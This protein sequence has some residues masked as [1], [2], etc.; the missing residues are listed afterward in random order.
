[1]SGS[2]F[3]ASSKE[4]Y[5]SESILK[6]ETFLSKN[7]ELIYFFHYRRRIGQS[8]RFCGDNNEENLDH[9]TISQDIVDVLT[10]V[11][12]YITRLLLKSIDCNSVC[13]KCKIALTN[14]P[15]SST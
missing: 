12:G 1:M 9:I 2:R 5:G 4:L 11:S 13:E 6:L 3:F 7:I 8:S 15:V 10:L 14:D